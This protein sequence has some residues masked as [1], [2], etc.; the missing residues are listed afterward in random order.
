MWSATARVTFIEDSQNRVSANTS[1][2]STCLS[3]YVD[4][5][6][7]GG[8]NDGEIGNGIDSE[9]S[10]DMSMNGVGLVGNCETGS[11]QEGVGTLAENEPFQLVGW[12]TDK[13][14]SPHLPFWK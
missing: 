5:G 6:E 10:W 13:F 12:R 9:A 1:G 2:D 4:V 11:K 7:S 3:R 14:N 8:K